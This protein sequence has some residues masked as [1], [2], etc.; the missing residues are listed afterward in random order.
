MSLD[1]DLLRSFVAVA[2]TQSFTVAGLQVGATQS[3]VSVR[4]KKLE[5]RLGR[6]LFERTP[7]SVEL[8]PA[9]RSFL[10]D[11]RRILAAHDDALRRAIVGEAA[12]SLAIGVA[13]H[14][15]G[16]TLAPALARV[17]GLMP[18]LKI[19]VQLGLSDVL[20]AAF[21]AGRLDAVVIRRAPGGERGRTLY[22]DDLCFC[23]A[24]DLDWRPGEPVPL[25]GVESPCNTRLT[26]VRA[27]DGA[28]IPWTEVFVSRGVAAV[29]A[30]AA[31]GLG[32][33]CLGRRFRPAG[34]VILG[35]ESG[36][37]ALP[38]SE[39]VLLESARDPAARMAVAGIAD[40]LVAAVA[41]EAVAA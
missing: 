13:E 5:E 9:G 27:L 37:P 28:G 3:A 41:E 23:A 32:I 2:D 17:R 31:A 15:G 38:S 12:V 39:V 34:T 35:R 20:L 19:E 1:I 25:V 14:A 10:P 11:A 29:Q 30:A 26:V 8:T 24:P 33:A 18:R 16:L 4:L 6:V 7:R 21:D 22:R 40:A 36:L